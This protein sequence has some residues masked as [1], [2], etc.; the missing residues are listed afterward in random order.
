[1]LNANVMTQP[2]GKTTIF[3]ECNPKKSECVLTHLEYVEC[4]LRKSWI[5]ALCSFN[6]VLLARPN[7]KAK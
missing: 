1:M 3:M 7:D 5:R 6:K 2:K 4:S